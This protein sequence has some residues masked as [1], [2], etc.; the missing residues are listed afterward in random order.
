M[1]TPIEVD[2]VQVVK[3]WI[4]ER[5]RL[6]Q[7]VADQQAE[8]LRLRGELEE[9]V[10]LSERLASER[11]AYRR[12]VFALRPKDEAPFTDKD[13]AEWERTGI[14]LEEFIH[15]IEEFTE[16]IAPSTP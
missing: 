12:D 13:V 11:D 3:D 15:E 5:D 2:A 9:A 1:S 7:Q 16:K 6:R 10:R 4:A 8:L 14:P